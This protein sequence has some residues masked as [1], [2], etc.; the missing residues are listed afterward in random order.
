MMKI[1]IQIL[2]GARAGQVSEF[3]DTAVIRL[4]RRPGNDVQFDV[5]RDLDVSGNHAEIRREADGFFLYDV[6]SAP[7][8]LL[9]PRPPTPWLQA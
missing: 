5:Q 1:V 9:L 3:T 8:R 6:G 2:T 4:G 7:L